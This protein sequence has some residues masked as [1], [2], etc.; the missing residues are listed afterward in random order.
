MRMC[1]YLVNTKNDLKETE[2]RFEK[3]KKA[4]EGWKGIKGKLP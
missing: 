1:K 4:F 3:I 2:K